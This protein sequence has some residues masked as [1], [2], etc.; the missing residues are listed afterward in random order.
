MK[1]R[2]VMFA[3][4]M[5]GIPFGA[6]GSEQ[7]DCRTVLNDSTCPNVGASCTGDRWMKQCAC[8]IKC[9]VFGPEP[10]QVTPSGSATCGPTGEACE[11]DI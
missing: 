1:A 6:N 11:D 5:L 7:W 2:M 3:I 10:G 9:L 8:K 4:L